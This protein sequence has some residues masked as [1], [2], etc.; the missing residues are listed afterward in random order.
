MPFISGESICRLTDNAAIP[1]DPANTDYQQ[2]KTDVANGAPLEDPDGNVMTQ[3]QIN[4]FL[5]TL[6]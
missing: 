6:P 4:S 5:E 3:E 1:M 2:F